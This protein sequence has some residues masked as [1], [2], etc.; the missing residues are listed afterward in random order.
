MHDTP[1]VDPKLRHQSQSIAFVVLQCH[2]ARLAWLSH[3]FPN[4]DTD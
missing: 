4:A 3:L 2:S 1:V